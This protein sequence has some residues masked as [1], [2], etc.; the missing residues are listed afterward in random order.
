[1]TAFRST[2]NGL[3]SIKCFHAL[4]LILIGLILGQDSLAETR[5]ALIIGIN[6]YSSGGTGDGGRGKWTDLG[7]SLND[8]EGLREILVSKYGF[9]RENITT[10]V[11]KE[12]T[13]K[14]ILTAY[15]RVLVAPVQ[16]DDV[17]LFYYAG[18]GSQV[19]NSNST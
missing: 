12:A 10:L 7:G 6:D 1:M 13:R 3:R 15:N 17:C 16:K 14:N 5:R 8:A 4:P 9:K 11:N 19:M 18:H 2:R